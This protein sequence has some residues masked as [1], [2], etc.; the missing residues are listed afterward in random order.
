MYYEIFNIYNIVSRF[1]DGDSKRSISTIVQS[2][3][4]VEKIKFLFPRLDRCFIILLHTHAS[5]FLKP[6]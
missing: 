4:Q 1:I 5:F 3:N 2:K 6:N